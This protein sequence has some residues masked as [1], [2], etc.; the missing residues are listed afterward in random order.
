MR[1]EL[2]QGA[3]ASVCPLSNFLANR[4]LGRGDSCQVTRSP[5]PCQTLQKLFLTSSHVDSKN[6]L[7]NYISLIRLFFEDGIAGN[8][9]R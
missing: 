7:D 2:N 8:E 6:I 9:G 5:D 3:A 4:I 1:L